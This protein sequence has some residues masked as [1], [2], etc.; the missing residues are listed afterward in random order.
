MNNKGKNNH[1][2]GKT[3]LS[4]TREKIKL[5]LRT[6]AFNKILTDETKLKIY[7]RSRGITVKVYDHLNNLISQ[8]YSMTKVAKQFNV[9]VL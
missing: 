4:E 3:R 7:L 8:F 1:L 5:I 2:L 9:D 6:N